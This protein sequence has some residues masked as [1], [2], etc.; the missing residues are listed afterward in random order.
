MAME[1]GK[2]SKMILVLIQLTNLS[3]EVS[4]QKINFTLDLPDISQT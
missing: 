1:D 2:I 4:M 3:K